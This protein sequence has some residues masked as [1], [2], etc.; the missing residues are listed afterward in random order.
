MD[1]NEKI[2]KVS[3]GFED[4]H[5]EEK[6]GRVR[7]LF[8]NVA[9]KYDIMND[10]M[11]L[12]VHRLWKN[13]FVSMISPHP[14]KT[15]LDMAGGTGDIALRLAQKIGS[16]K[17]IIVCDLTADM[18]ERGM[19]RT[20]P[21]NQEIK[22]VCASAEDLPFPDNSFDV[23]TISFGIRNVT[24]IEKALSEA[25]RVLKSGGRFICLE[26]A[27]PSLRGLD[28]IYDAYSFHILPQMGKLIAN[29]AD[30]YRYLA[31][32]IRRFPKQEVFAQMI[33]KAGFKNVSFKNLS[34][35]ITAIHSGYKVT[36]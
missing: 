9:D 11:S 27:M 14:D 26:F 2:E 10:V 8:A 32:S 30:S 15:Y 4:I 17:N 20:E 12:G 25:Y 5:V 35:G 19:K 33:Q 1:K 23:Y 22:R 3:F 7:N 34:A 21:Y 28:K 24:R 29:D 36:L 18:L 13:L 31:E 6:S 16:G